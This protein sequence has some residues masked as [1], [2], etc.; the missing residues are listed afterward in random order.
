M[1]AVILFRPIPFGNTVPALAIAI[2]AL[3]VLE[4]HGLAAISGTPVCVAG[5]AIAS[6]VV[7]GLM[8]GAIFIVQSVILSLN[9]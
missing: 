5:L 8:K 7:V 6:G 2:M 1:L 9:R 4:W 3:A